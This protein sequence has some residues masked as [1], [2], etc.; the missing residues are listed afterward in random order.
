MGPQP[1]QQRYDHLAHVAA[2]PAGVATAALP[3]PTTAP[4]PP[5]GDPR[6]GRG[7][8]HQRS[9]FESMNTALRR[10]DYPESE[11]REPFRFS[12][13]TLRSATAITRT[14]SPATHRQRTCWP[15]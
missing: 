2:E 3:R 7:G 9:T 12:R 6:R 10:D 11:R 8:A 4:H 1:G 15:R 13:A 14:S 5:T